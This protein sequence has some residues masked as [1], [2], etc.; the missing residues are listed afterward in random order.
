MRTEGHTKRWEALGN[1]EFEFGNQSAERIRS[2][3]A[4]PGQPAQVGENLL[5]E[6]ARSKSFSN[7][8]MD[9]T[10]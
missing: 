5:S 4:L 3:P 6:E 8:R 10:W 7:Q 2:E 9:F 1:N